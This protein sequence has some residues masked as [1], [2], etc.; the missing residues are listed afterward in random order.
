M[1]K[2][3]A[4]LIA[5]IL[6]LSLV[7]CSENDNDNSEPKS[8]EPTLKDANTYEKNLTVNSEAAVTET[9][10]V[11][12]KTA[13]TASLPD[14]RSD[15]IQISADWTDLEFV[16]DNSKITLNATTLSD[17]LNI[18]WST[19]MSTAWLK[20]SLDEPMRGTIFENFTLCKEAYPNISDNYEVLLSVSVD[21]NTL[22]ESLSMKD[23]Y[24]IG[25]SA[26]VGNAIDNSSAYPNI[27][28]QGNITFGSKK[29]EIL[30]AFAATNYIS[31]TTDSY[32]SIPYGSKSKVYETE[33]IRYTNGEKGMDLTVDDERG[34]T[35]IHIYD[36]SNN[37]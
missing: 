33:I 21:L 35:A 13:N 31:E 23:T 27:M 15:T 4:F 36:N 1:M 24:I 32:A 16:F 9:T 2:K 19:D 12:E 28:L 7:S 10:S 26:D 25:F 6:S 17:L 37:S 18:G 5:L 22:G 14:S 3:A 29:E 20:N 8:L 30:A 11:A 34:L